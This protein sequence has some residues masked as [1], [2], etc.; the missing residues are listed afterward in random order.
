M[1]SVSATLENTIEQDVSLEMYSKV[2]AEW[3]LNAYYETTVVAPDSISDDMF[4]ADSIALPRRPKRSGLPKTIVNHFRVTDHDTFPRYRVPTRESNYKYFSSDDQSVAGGAIGPLTFAVEYQNSAPCNKITIGFEVSDSAPTDVELQVDYGQGWE[5]EGSLPAIGSDGRVDLYRQSGGQWTE[6]EHHNIDNV[7]EIVGARIIVSAMDGSSNPVGVIQLSPRLSIDISDRIISAGTSRSAEDHT[8]SS[9][10]GNAASTTAN[11]QFANDDRLFDTENPDSIL[12]GMIDKNVMLTISYLIT[13][14]DGV[15][16]EVPQGV[17]YVE[18]WDVNYTVEGG[19][20]ATD[21]SKFLQETMIEDSFYTGMPVEYVVTDIL[22]RQGILDYQL[23][24]AADDLD[25]T[26]PYT[27]FKGEQSIWEALTSLALA[28]Q[29]QF[30]FDE[31]DTFV[32]TS[33]DYT[34]ESDTPVWELRDEMNGSSLPNIFEFTPTFNV[35]AN[36]VDVK[37]QPYEIAKQGDEE[38]NNTLW[39]YNETLVLEAAPLTQDFLAEHITVDIPDDDWDFFPYSGLIN[40]GGEF[41]TYNKRDDIRGQ[42]QVVDRGVLNTTPQDHFVKPVDNDWNFHTLKWNGSGFDRINGN[43]TQGRHKIRDSYVEIVSPPHVDRRTLSQIMTGNLSS[44]Y[45]LYGCSMVFPLSRNASNEP[46]YAAGGAAGLV[47]NNGGMESGYYVEVQPTVS[48]DKANPPRA[49]VTVRRW[50]NGVSRW[51]HG[52]SNSNYAYAP[53]TGNR[54]NIVPGRHHQLE[55]H[56]QPVGVDNNI[57]VIVDGVVVLSFLDDQ[58]GAKRQNGF[59]GVYGR[60]NTV[61][62]FDAA[63]AIDK[64]REKGEVINIIDAVRDRTEGGYVSNTLNNAL[65]SNNQEWAEVVYEDFGPIVH[66]GFE[67]VIDYDISPAISSDVFISNDNE[68]NEIYHKR[69]PFGSRFAIINAHRQPAVAV[70][71]DPSRDNQQMSLF[72]YGKPVVEGSESSVRVKDEQSILRIG[73]Q[74]LEVSSPWIQTEQRAQR[75][76]DWVTNRWGIPNDVAEVQTIVVPHLQLGDL[77]SIL[78]SDQHMSPATHKYNVV[79]IEKEV[80]TNTSMTV[81][82]RRRR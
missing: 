81:T 76:A 39:E 46:Y 16:E 61:V 48:A 15:V 77:V 3:E 10:I 57:I 60:G 42:L 1:Q 47:I 53:S 45:S 22:Q 49:E 75:I 51:A 58:P 66:Q 65:H 20:S 44:T 50:A 21:Y 52:P 7:V 71:G 59:W 72:I 4:P 82:L 27:F 24:Y 5:S 55:V 63:W 74:E 12:N 30:Y 68:I 67:F 36:D 19:A 54:F 26:V 79:G 64:R 6:S 18:E 43:S 29:A 38:V 80:G 28:E 23:N 56:I 14:S 31:E 70:G 2:I 35:G 13:R 33:R 78:S 41:I 69:T 32:W 40:L 17:F 62:R 25:L 8:I 11:I 37:Y 73:A 9:P 34:W